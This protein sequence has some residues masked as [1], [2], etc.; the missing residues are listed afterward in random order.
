[1]KKFSLLLLLFSCFILTACNNEVKEN[2]TLNDFEKICNSLNIEVKDNLQNYTT[3][4]YILGSRLA[5]VNGYDVEMIIYDTVDN[6]K[7]VQDEQIDTFMKYRGTFV[8]SIKNKGKNFYEYK[9]V[10]NGYY[11]VSSRI[12]NTLVFAQIPID[13]QDSVDKLLNELGY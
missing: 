13:Y 8:T 9:L 5:T 7:K 1:M 11:M 10:S 6:A 2:K 12:D 4:S 3:D